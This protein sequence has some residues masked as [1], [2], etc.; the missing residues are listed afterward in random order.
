MSADSVE[1]ALSYMLAQVGKPYVWGGTGPRGYDCSGLG[2]MGY[3]AG[4]LSIPRATGGQQYAGTAVHGTNVGALLPGDAIFPHAGHVVWYL[5]GGRVVEAPKP[6]LN[7]RVTDLPSKIWKVR[8][9]ASVPQTA[10]TTQT[11]KAGFGFDDIGKALWDGTKQIGSGLEKGAEIGSEWSEHV[12]IVSGIGGAIGEGIDATQ[13]F[14]KL[15]AFI[16][17]PHNWYR[18]GLFVLG[19]AFLFIAFRKLAVPAAENVGVAAAGSKV[20]AKAFGKL[21]D[22]KGAA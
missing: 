3:R 6:G 21:A 13:A 20:G 14:I 5:G 12:P 11:L 9:F 2:Y 7:V 16:V 22:L 4:G 19:A 1:K 17:N 8:R 15:S 18:V 10:W